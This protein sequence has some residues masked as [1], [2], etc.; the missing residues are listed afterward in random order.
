MAGDKGRTSVSITTTT[1]LTDGLAIVL[2]L[3]ASACCIWAVASRP[4]DSHL[5]AKAAEVHRQSTP[6]ISRYGQ[7]P[8]L[9]GYFV[10]RSEEGAIE[11][12][13]SVMDE[14]ATGLHKSEKG[15]LARVIYQE[16]D[17]HGLDPLLLVALIYVESAFQN[18]SESSM[19]ARGL[20]QILPSVGR[21]VAQEARIPWEGD[22]TLH[23]PRKNIRIGAS[24]LKKL[25][26]EFEDLSLALAAY[27][28]GPTALKSRMKSGGRLPMA[29]TNKVMT[30]YHDLRKRSV[31]NLG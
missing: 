14:Y 7:A 2:M 9:P 24:Y 13:N 10:G 31:E 15:K 3:L 26:E 29:F 16:C 1:S 23:N 8:A 18:F 17:K 6:V 28:V 25:M 21:S 20:M 22:E 4:I 11:F 12:I 5:G 30:F 19:G 27:N